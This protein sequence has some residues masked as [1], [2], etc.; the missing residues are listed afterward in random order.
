MRTIDTH[1]HI[2]PE[3]CLELLPEPLA[4]SILVGDM[5]DIATR[6]KDMDDT[7]V[8]VQALS[9]F[10]ALLNKDVATA[11]Q[12]NDSLA[13]V[14]AQHPDRF[15]GLALAPMAEPEKAPAELDRAVN[16][17]GMVGVGI[18]SNIN[19]KNLD[20]KEL[21]PFYAKAQE[22]DIP[23]FIHPANVLGMDRLGDWYLNNFIGNVTDTAV[24]AASIIFGGVFQEFPNLKIYL[25]HGGGSCPYIRGR[26]D[27]GWKAHETGSK[28]TKPPSE[29]MRLFYFDA[30]THSSQTLQYLVE[31][32]GHDKVMLGS[33]YPFDM[34]DIDQVGHVNE[35]DFLTD[36]QKEDV[37]G[38]TAA[39][40]FKI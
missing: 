2:V 39:K 32:F 12:F 17:L 8:E 7:G 40:L 14:V 13:R 28:I 35:V 11:R 34:G 1:A 26:W 38:L 33:D 3:D 27:H 23:I 16:E 25:A 10:L 22:L 24:A 9:G 5:T 19:G 21:G 29:Y 36:A 20:A 15:V 31:S 18:A 30:L 37:M 4:K 6:L